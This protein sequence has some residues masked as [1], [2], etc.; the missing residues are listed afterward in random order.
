MSEAPRLSETRLLS[1][2]A[3]PH[4]HWS[5]A[6]SQFATMTPEMQLIFFQLEVRGQPAYVAAL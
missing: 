3:A 5:S 6:N 2:N 4:R 1:L